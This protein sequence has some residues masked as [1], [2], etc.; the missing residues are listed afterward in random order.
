MKLRRE[1]LIFNKIRKG[2]VKRVTKILDKKDLD[3]YMITPE[4]NTPLHVACLAGHNG[5]VK[6]LLKYDSSVKNIKNLDGNTPLH[7]AAFGKH[8]KCMEHLLNCGSKDNIP[9]NTG[10]LI[11][12]TMSKPITFT[13]EEDLTFMRQP[14][15]KINASDYRFGLEL[16]FQLTKDFIKNCPHKRDKLERTFNDF[17]KLLT[18]K[19]T[20]GTTFIG[21]GYDSDYDDEH[22][23]TRN[24]YITWDYSISYTR[25]IE[26]VSPVYK[27]T[28]QGFEKL[29]RD[30]KLIKTEL[31]KNFEFNKHCGLHL[32]LSWKNMLPEEIQKICMRYRN[33]EDRIKN[34]MPKNRRNYEYCQDLSTEINMNKFFQK[35]FSNP[36]IFENRSW[37]RSR[38]FGKYLAVSLNENIT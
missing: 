20:W 26:F 18:K 2:D 28:K 32:H 31:G 11:N 30:L 37:S 17:G 14:V 35:T 13:V 15:T 3:P 19:N 9:N 10:K 12:V 36:N 34:F 8:I 38:V 5:L 21:D 1:V 6:L 33:H 29:L 16:E 27:P 4:G 23:D 25:G 24:W 7:L 22:N